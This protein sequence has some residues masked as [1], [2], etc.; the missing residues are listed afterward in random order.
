M[1]PIR[2]AVA[3]T[4][5]LAA[6]L[7]GGAIGA[8]MIGQ[9][10]AATSATTSSSATSTTVAPAVGRGARPAAHPDESM[11]GHQANGITEALLT[12]STATKVEAAAK[13]AVPGGTILR[14]E[15]DAEGAKYEAHVRKADGSEVTV[16]V[17]AS[18][19]VTEVMTGPR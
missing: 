8:T 12:G 14:V 16:K 19:K 9:A 3:G 18:F 1:N 10:S 5:L 11:G 15:N 4:A 2:K 17:N 13:T 7:T 6:T